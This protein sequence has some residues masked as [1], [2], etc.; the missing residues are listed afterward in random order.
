VPSVDNC[1]ADLWQILTNAPHNL[2]KWKSLRPEEK[3]SNIVREL[4]KRKGISGI[5]K[6]ESEIGPSVKYDVFH[7]H[8]V[9][10]CYK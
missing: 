3:Y 6:A 5:V 8:N 2:E 9:R 4:K 10:S 7:I 1:C